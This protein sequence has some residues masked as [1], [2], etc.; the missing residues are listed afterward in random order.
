[1]YLK[2][3]S[4]VLA[5]LNTLRI[6]L[7]WYQK[8]GQIVKLTKQFQKTEITFMYFIFKAK[9]WKRAPLRGGE[10]KKGGGE[11]GGGRR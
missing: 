3:K 8:H 10:G 2:L 9:S 1:M 5:A 4:E 11:E 7:H 6:N